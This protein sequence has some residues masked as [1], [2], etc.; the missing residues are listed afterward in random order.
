MA[1]L[2]SLKDYYERTDY[3]VEHREEINITKGLDVVLFYSANYE[4]YRHP[5]REDLHL[6]YLQPLSLQIKR[7]ECKGELAALILEND[8]L[9]QLLLESVGKHHQTESIRMLER[10]LRTLSAR[11]FDL[12]A[13]GRG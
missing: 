6:V 10:E 13:T 8:R 12:V 7:V 1:H 11:S 4:V 2:E 9:H 3:D 5:W